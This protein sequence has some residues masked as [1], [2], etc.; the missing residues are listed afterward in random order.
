[1]SNENG[2]QDLVMITTKQIDD[3]DEFKLLTAT[4][5]PFYIDIDS[6]ITA[7]LTNNHSTQ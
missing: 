5:W 6:T 2:S 4:K 3:L 1:M 7:K